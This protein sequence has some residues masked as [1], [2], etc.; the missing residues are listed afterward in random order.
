MEKLYTFHKLNKR[1]PSLEVDDHKELLEKWSFSRRLKIDCY[2]FNEFY[3]P[4]NSLQLIKCLLK[5]ENVDLPFNS[6]KLLPLR[7][8][9]T[10]MNYFDPLISDTCYKSE[11]NRIKK[12]IPEYVNVDG[13]EVECG[14]HLRSFLFDKESD[15]MIDNYEKN[16]FLHHLL[17][18][19]SLGGTPCCQ[20]E[21]NLSTYLD[22]IRQL[23]KDFIHVEK[24]SDNGQ[25]I[26][27]STIYKCFPFD[28]LTPN[29]TVELLN[30]EN[31]DDKISFEFCF[32]IILHV[33]KE[34]L[35]LSSK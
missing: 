6:M 13:N 17:M 15:L 26:I 29:G 14:D 4:S 8:T 12:H 16:E 19:L 22:V 10:S 28:Q 7:V 30:E 32:I 5:S 3:I 18:Q 33:K 1:F 25:F 27:Q 34:I 11:E 31:V 24:R 2:L 21:D 23:Y 9:K 20:Y 35:I